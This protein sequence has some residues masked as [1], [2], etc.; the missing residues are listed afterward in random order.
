MIERNLIIVRRSVKHTSYL[1]LI[2]KLETNDN[3]LKGKHKNYEDSA[4]ADTGL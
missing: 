4:I 3:P 1:L 2:E